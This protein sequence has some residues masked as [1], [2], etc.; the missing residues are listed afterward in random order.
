MKKTR[1]EWKVIIKQYMLSGM[2]KKKFASTNKL[3]YHAF[4]NHIYQDGSLE[5][6]CNEMGMDIS[7]FVRRI[8][9]KVKIFSR[10]GII[11]VEI[12]NTVLTN[13]TLELKSKYGSITIDE[14]TDL[15]LLKKVVGV[16]NDI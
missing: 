2:N 9:P 14:K 1:A 12:N 13:N 5:E 3:S 4:K 10:V 15:K 11:P 8:N 6:L 16:I 7:K